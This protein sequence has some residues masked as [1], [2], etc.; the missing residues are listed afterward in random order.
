MNAATIA[1]ALRHYCDYPP[2]FCRASWHPEIVFG[3]G[4]VVTI[5]TRHPMNEPH[6]VRVRKVTP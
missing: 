3:V 2:Q 5:L 6:K 1:D 4:Y